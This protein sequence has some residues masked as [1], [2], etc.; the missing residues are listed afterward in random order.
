MSAAQMKVWHKCFKDSQESVESDP[1]SGR[2]ATNRTPEN[3]KHVWAAI[4]KDQR[5]V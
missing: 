1:H 3:V 4:S 5:T 2:P